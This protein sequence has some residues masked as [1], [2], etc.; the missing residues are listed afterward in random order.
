[1]LLL[2]GM[3]HRRNASARRSRRNGRNPRRGG[4]KVS[5]LVTFPRRSMRVKRWARSGM[6]TN[7]AATLRGSL[8]SV[9]TGFKPKAVMGVLPYAAGAAVNAWVANQVASRFLPAGWGEGWKGAVVS[10]A[11]AGALGGIAGMYKKE[12]G[13]KVFTGAMI[14]TLI[15]GGM[16]IFAAIKGSA[17]AIAAPAAAPAAPAAQLSGNHDHEWAPEMA[18]M[19]T[20]EE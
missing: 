18:D 15:A 6:F 4:R 3:K 12:V 7:P 16:A 9:T 17:A 2:N 19:E 10:T 8:S 5:S 13:M 11:T 1:M 20:V 14:P